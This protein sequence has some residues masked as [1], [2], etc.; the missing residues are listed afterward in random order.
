MPG[1]ADRHAERNARQAK[2]KGDEPKGGKITALLDDEGPRWRKDRRPHKPKQPPTVQRKGK[3]PI[4]LPI[5]VR[6]LSEAIGKKHGEVMFK[7][8]APRGGDDH[9][10][11]LP[12][13]G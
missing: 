10:H 12:H 9:E 5:T 13:P 11:Q 6:S 2:R 1:R 3:T 4:S 8:I 7:M